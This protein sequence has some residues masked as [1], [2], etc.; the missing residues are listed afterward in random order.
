MVYCENVAAGVMPTS[1]ILSQVLGCL[2]FPYDGSLKSRLIENQGISADKS[3]PSNL[4]SLLDGFGEYDPRAFSLLQVSREKFNIR[5]L[6]SMETM[7]KPCDEIIYFRKLLHLELY[8]VFPS[9]KTWLLLMQGGWRCI[10]LR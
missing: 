9:K 10:L 3:R 6:L 8:S 4:C 5:L 2:Q 7:W 1:D